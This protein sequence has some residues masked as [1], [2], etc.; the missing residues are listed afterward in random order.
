VATPPPGEELDRRVQIEVFREGTNSAPPPYSTDMT[1]ATVVVRKMAQYGWRYQQDPA[2]DMG[3]PAFRARF[4]HDEGS[5]A[6]IAD[7]ISVSEPHAI[8]LAAL[9]AVQKSAPPKP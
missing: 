9:K 3:R 1:W 8:C 4:Q 5:I 2:Q 7:E 6:N